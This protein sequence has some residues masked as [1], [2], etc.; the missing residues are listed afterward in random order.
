M[1]FPKGY[2]WLGKVGQLPKTISEA[3]ALHGTAEIVGRGSN[4]TIMA[5]RDELNQA[6]GVSPNAVKIDGYSDDDI[7]WC[8]LFAAIVTFRAGKKVVAQ[9]LWA[10]NWAKFG[11][12]VTEAGLGD[13]LVFV[14]NGGGH[15]GFYV[16]HDATTYHVLGG[17]QGNKVSITRIAKNRCIAVRRPIYNAKPE[18]V[19]PFK[20]AASGAVS[21]NEA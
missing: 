19:R 14:R 12:G 16:G 8:G 18:G 15:V 10:R 1:T 11:V 4:K 13:V 21:S 7:P 5:W 17:N 2:E 20:V 6:A 3:L 9:P